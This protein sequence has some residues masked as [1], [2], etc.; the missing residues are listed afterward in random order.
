MM[1]LLGFVAGTIFGALVMSSY[2]S[3]QRARLRRQ[4]LEQRL[5]RPRSR[6]QFQGY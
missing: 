5:H 4:K 1:L 3:K 6:K 2:E